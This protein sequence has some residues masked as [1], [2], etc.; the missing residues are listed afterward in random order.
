MRKFLPILLLFFACKKNDPPLQKSMFYDSVKG[1]F[2]KY[3][4]LDVNEDGNPDIKLGFGEIPLGTNV[5][6]YYAVALHSQTKVHTLNYKTA[7]CRDT[8]G[9]VPWQSIIEHNC[10]GGA[11]QIRVD[12]FYAAPNLDSTQLYN[13]TV[14]SVPYDSVLIHSA[15]FKWYM[16]TSPYTYEEEIVH[17]FFT[18]A[19]TGFLLFEVNQ[20]RY[21]VR[22]NRMLSMPFDTTISN[23]RPFIESLIKIDP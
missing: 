2:F 18:N 20:K 16:P 11:T 9:T 8:L 23:G 17:G 1:D 15:S 12:S 19:I 7:I 6:Y 4:R 13:T 21:G 3:Y 10:N 22:L 5:T 14:K